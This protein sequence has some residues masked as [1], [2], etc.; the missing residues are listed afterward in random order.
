M[1]AEDKKDRIINFRYI[2]YPFLL[3]LFGLSVARQLFAGQ[4]EVV[5]LTIVFLCLLIAFCIYKKLFIPLAILLSFFFIGNGMYYV[6]EASFKVK[7]Y[8]GVVAVVGRVTDDID[9]Y[10][11]FANVLLDE[12]SIDGEKTNYKFNLSLSSYYKTLKAGDIVSFECEVSTSQPFI[13]GKFNIA[14]NRSG[15]R[16]NGQVKATELI[17]TEGYTKFD[18]KVRLT[19]KERLFENMSEQNAGIAYAVLFGDKSELGTTIATTYRASGIVHVLT[20]SG[21]HVGFLVALIYG[22]L[23]KCGANKYFRFVIT[24]IFIIFYAYLCGFTP[25]VLRAGIMSIVYMLSKVLFRNYDSLNSLGLAGFVICLINPLTAHDI[26]FLMSFFCVYSIIMLCPLITKLLSSFFPYNT[27]QLIALS[28]SANI[29][30]IPFLAYIGGSV[31][32][33]SFIINLV[34]VPIFSIL[35]PFLFATSMLATFMPFVGVMLAVADFAFSLITSLATFFAWSG[36]TIPL[37][38]FDYGIIIVIFFTILGISQFVLTE[39]IK[40]FVFFSVSSL[41]LVLTAFLYRIPLYQGSF[42]TCLKSANEESIVI[43]NSN[44]EKMVIGKCELLDDYQNNYQTGNF[45]IFMAMDELKDSNLEELDGLGFYQFVTY[46]SDSENDIVGVVNFNTF[47]QIGHFEF[48]YLGYGGE[49]LGI[50]IT[51]DQS[52][53]FVA[54]KTDYDY[55]YLNSLFLNSLNP[56]IVVAWDNN[57]YAQGEYICITNQNINGTYNHQKNGNFELILNGNSWK[58]REID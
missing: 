16:Y 56:D 15:A 4:I 49:F 37:S 35:Y 54:S 55:N 48:S 8:S 30:V 50:Y 53:I 27:S 12:V 36:L 2:F 58:V 6:G 42:I 11:Y 10:N 39:G 23:K 32:L 46:K 1:K 24:T 25:S 33:L 31:H 21:L 47:Y 51:F 7:Q 38:A 17:I 34:I 20:V 44:S 13:L 5:I 52:T 28:I 19:I 18:E 14:D 29:G 43:T 41:V 26:G 3:F 22:L 9:E 45:D 40:K 57:Q